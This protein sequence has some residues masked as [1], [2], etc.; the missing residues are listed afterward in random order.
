M[1]RRAWKQTVAMIAGVLAAACAAAPDGGTG[2]ADPALTACTPP[3]PQICT[4]NYDP[5]CGRVGDGS[6]GTYANAC[7]ACGDAD[8][9]GHRPG[10]CE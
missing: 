4:A 6:Y 10:A 8:V 7:M 9:S 3:R 2:A 5:V 1:S